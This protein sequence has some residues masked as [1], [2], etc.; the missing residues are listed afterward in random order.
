MASSSG[1]LKLGFYLA[2]V[3]LAVDLLSNRVLSQEPWDFSHASQELDSSPEAQDLQNATQFDFGAFCLDHI[4]LGTVTAVSRPAVHA[5]GYWRSVTLVMKDG[6]PVHPHVFFLSG[7]P[8]VGGVFTACSGSPGDGI[9]RI[10]EGD[11]QSGSITFWI[12]SKPVANFSLAQQIEPGGMDIVLSKAKSKLALLYG[13]TVG[14]QAFKVMNV[15]RFV[16]NPRRLDQAEGGILSGTLEV[17]SRTLSITGAKVRMPGA[18]GAFTANFR[19]GADGASVLIAIPSGAVSLHRGTEATTT[20]LTSSSEWTSS[21][22]GLEVIAHGWRI[23]KVE[24]R[25]YAGKQA[26]T[27]TLAGISAAASHMKHGPPTFFDATPSKPISISELSGTLAAD[28]GSAMPASVVIKGLSVEGNMSVGG[29][30]GTPA[31]EGLGAADVQLLTDTAADATIRMAKPQMNSLGVITEIGSTNLLLGVRGEKKAPSLSGEVGVV[32]AALGGLALQRMTSSLARFSRSADA[33]SEFGVPFTL[34]T[35]TAGG[36]WSLQT[37]GGPVVLS[38]NTGGLRASGT[39]WFGSDKDPPRIT[40]DP[41]TFQLAAEGAVV[42]DSL[43]FGAPAE[44][45]QISAALDL[46]SPSGF[47]IAKHGGAR[48]AIDVDA[49]LLVIEQPQLSFSIDEPG[50]IRIA[51]PLRFEAGATL[52]V[53]LATLGVKLHRGHAEVTAA[54]ASAIDPKLPIEMSGLEIKA[55][56]LTLGSLVIDVQDATGVVSIKDLAAQTES[57]SHPRDLQW[58]AAAG[59]LSVHA[60]DATLVDVTQGV[61]LRDVTVADLEVKAGSGSYSS[62][63]GFHI[64]GGPVQISA[65]AVTRVSISNAVITIGGGNLS[66]NSASDDANVSASASFDSFKVSA[67]G[68]GEDINGDIHLHIASISGSD[69]FAPLKKKCGTDLQLQLSLG[70]G[71]ISIDGALVHGDARGQTA[72]NDARIALH[73][74]NSDKCEW[75]E[76]YPVNVARLVSTPVCH[77]PLIGKKICSVEQKLVNVEIDVPVMWRAQVIALNVA[78]KADSVSLALSGRKGVSV[79]VN[80]AHADSVGKVQTVTVTPTFDAHGGLANL[81]KKV[82]DASWQTS[83]GLLESAI[84]TSLINIASIITT[85]FPVS[86]CS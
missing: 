38:G 26:P 79:C 62:H 13:G 52:S 70:M 54:S 58:S 21:V 27:I 86:H 63:D 2:V 47:T 71:S 22:A 53:E 5:D 6:A 74:T 28:D 39:V 17:G 12:R 35:P 50:R 42:R 8:Q 33:A 15:D 56:S 3:C 30:P 45:I 55:P 85:M 69:V 49:G 65:D 32:S 59:T 7:T 83:L 51:A 18:D 4:P 57:I 20:A 64:E 10:L 41:G 37:P 43:A 34:K 61:Q 76:R 19:P 24:M 11:I 60:V 67:S 66:V 23:N 44:S 78:V 31:I 84:E 1:R 72:S 9:T 48:G 46:S 25:G 40:V 81:V 14:G 36:S 82:W 77:I 80:G 73:K 68:T 75:H 16:D 29:A